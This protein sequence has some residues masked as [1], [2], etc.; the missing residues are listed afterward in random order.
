MYKSR[1]INLSIKSSKSNKMNKLIKKTLESV[2]KKS[3]YSLSGSSFNKS[4]LSYASSVFTSSA[5]SKQLRK[6]LVSVST[7]SILT[8]TSPSKDHVASEFFNLCFDKGR[9]KQ[10]VLWFSHRHGE[11]KTVKL[12]EQL[13]T[14]GFEHARKAGISLGIDDLVVPPIKAKLLLEADK[15]TIK[16]TQHFRCGDI[17]G[18]ERFQ[19]LIN[20]WHNTSEDLKNEVVEHYRHQHPMNPVYMMAFSGARGNI[21][22]VR[23]LVGMRGLMADPQGRIIDYPIRS[24]FRE[25]ITLTEYLISC[26]GARKGIVD[27][28][29]RTADAGYLTRRLVDVAQHVIVTNF[30]CKTRR[31]I[32]L[33]DIKEGDTKIHSLTKRAIGR[34]LATSLIHNTQIDEVDKTISETSHATHFLGTTASPI[35][36][37]PITASPITA[38]P[39][40]ASPITASPI[41]VK[42]KQSINSVLFKRNQEITSK[43]ASVIAKKYSRVFVRSPLTCEMSVCQLCYGW[44]LA[45]GNLVAIGEAVGVVAAQ[46]IGEPGTQLTM[47]TFHTGG[48]FSGDVQDVIRAPFDGII[49]FDSPIPG[50]LVRMPEGV[51]AFLTKSEGSLHIKRYA[52]NN[53]ITTDHPDSSVNSD[54]L[55][56]KRGFGLSTH[57]VKRSFKL[58]AY[59]ILYLRHG[60]HVVHKQMIARITNND[61][62]TLTD[63]AEFT[64]NSGLEGL[65]YIQSAD[66][67]LSNSSVSKPPI[68]STWGY[69]WVLSGSA[70][71]PDSFFS[72]KR[73]D[74]TATKGVSLEKRV[75]SRRKSVIGTRRVPINRSVCVR[76][77]E[78]DTSDVHARD[79]VL[80]STIIEQPINTINPG[81]LPGTS[82]YSRY[83]HLS[84]K[85]ILTILK[86]LK[87]NIY[88]SF[89]KK[90]YVNF[91]RVESY[92]TRIDE[93]DPHKTLRVTEDRRSRS[94]VYVTGGNKKV[95]VIPSIDFVDPNKVVS[96]PSDDVDTKYRR[97]FDN[98][99]RIYNNCEYRRSRYNKNNNKVNLNCPYT[100][101]IVFI[102]KVNSGINKK[103]VNTD[104]NNKNPDLTESLTGLLLLSQA[105]LCSFYYSSVDDKTKVHK[106][107]YTGVQKTEVSA[108][109]SG[110]AFTG[111][112]RR[113]DLNY[114]RL[115]DP[116]GAD[117]K[118]IRSPLNSNRLLG[119]FLT[120]GDCI[121]PPTTRSDTTMYRL[122]RP[123]QRIVTLN[124]SN[125]NISEKNKLEDKRADRLEKAGF[126]IDKENG[127]LTEGEFKRYAYNKETSSR[128]IHY[129]RNKVTLRRAQPF[130]YSP[131]AVL[132][133]THNDIVEKQAP[134]V[135]LQYERLVTGDIVQGIPKI[136]QLFE[137]RRGKNAT[138]EQLHIKGISSRSSLPV[139]LKAMFRS[140]KASTES[141]RYAQK[142][143]RH[144]RLL[145]ADRCSISHIQQI[146]VDGVQR[147]YQSQGVTIADKHLEIIVKQMTSKVRVIRDEGRGTVSSHENTGD[148]VVR[149]SEF[150]NTD[151]RRPSGCTFF[152]GELV[153]REYIEKINSTL[154]HIIPYE[155][156]VLGISQASLRVSSFLSAS[157][158]QHTTTL[159]AKSAVYNKQDF[160]RGLKEKV[161]LGQLIPAGTGM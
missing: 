53:R 24:N 54:S 14:I 114:L 85:S 96:I 122:R 75:Q 12:V 73:G 57:D 151:V 80:D 134:V 150:N 94:K 145:I 146:I 31:G 23:Q 90:N 40:T 100:G 156:V 45:R 117:Q 138:L 81:D 98:A 9:L 7:S 126:Y 143:D 157:S 95:I 18:V 41:A 19:R 110:E 161:M 103:S 135:T 111:R 55:N 47:R 43:I 22:Q 116:M 17:T 137:A 120:Y 121:Q 52:S 102:K 159:L 142:L 15:V 36:A 4:K 144:Q 131:Q 1:R 112:T 140:Y 118:K 48:V 119:G 27:T 11:H 106:K 101:E 108:R 67:R 61:A 37:S 35:T 130:Y 50:T 56:N 139:I 60:Q 147:V 84:T 115:E 92:L 97:G 6:K 129:N 158:F 128:I 33:T 3:L 51:V 127:D 34:V 62:N 125:N 152:D 13:K 63:A 42:Q 72:P 76:I 149:N 88:K 49:V 38:S 71:D 136:E 39:I 8:Y 107:E 58:P 10:F 154:T 105:D 91:T 16:T 83:A 89:S 153:D 78:V 59:A 26:Y 2:T 113:G 69:S 79:R 132:H 74:F 160:L 32:Y 104:K 30:D 109:F 124:N 82:T 86:T 66:I 123:S 148:K 68:A 155:P 29:L 64:I 99:K 20:V 21:S 93:V 70:V 65:F 44:G 28:A 141:R 87:L 5:V 133:K 77:D 25:G 46:S